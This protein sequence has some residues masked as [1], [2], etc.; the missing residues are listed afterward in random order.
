LDEKELFPYGKV[1]VNDITSD[2][3][4]KLGQPNVARIPKLSS[5]RTLQKALIIYYYHM[6]HLI[7]LSF[8]LGYLIEEINFSKGNFL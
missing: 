4:S 6:G 7:K 1:E 3:N 5:L 8:V 2:K